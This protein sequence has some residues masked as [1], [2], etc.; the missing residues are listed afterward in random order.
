MKESKLM[1]K[2]AFQNI[3][4]NKSVYLPYIIASIFVL[5]TYF[6]F[7]LVLKSG[8]ME[9]VPR[10]SYAM[11]LVWIGFHLL[12]MILIPFLYYINSF[13]IKRR[14]SELGLYS[15]LGLEKK[16]IGMMM[17][18]ESLYI[19][20]VVYVIAVIIGLLFSKLVF[21]LLS[22][23]ADLEIGTSLYINPAIFKDV[24]LFYG[25]VMLLNLFV[26]LVQ[27]GK[28]KPVDLMSGSKKGEKE[29]KH[30]LP[31][32]LI[33]LL[34]TGYGYYM[35][36]TSGVDS[37]VFMS[38]FLAVALVSGGTHFL[39]TSGSIALL[40]AL[41]KKK[42][43]YYSSK[44]FIMISGMLYRMKKNAASLANICIFSTM[45]TIALTCTIVVMTG[46]DGVVKFM[47]PNDVE[48]TFLN[49]SAE[50][51]EVIREKVNEI[52]ASENTTLT[53]YMDV[54]VY[55]VS[56][57]KVE[58]QFLVRDWERPIGIEDRYTVL[59]MELNEYNRLQ[60]TAETLE[61]DEVL[62]FTT[63][64]DY[65]YDKIILTDG[66]Y[67]AKELKKCFIDNKA[68]L[69]TF[70]AYYVIV[71]PGKDKMDQLAASY[72]ADLSVGPETIHKFKVD[73]QDTEYA[74]FYEKVN[75]D[76]AAREGFADI[77]DT[78]EMGIYWGGLFGGLIFIGIF[79]S[80]IFIICLLVI[81]YYKQIAEGYEDQK[82]FDTMQKE[83]SN[84]R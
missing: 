39:F 60:E 17:F 51:K 42:G 6:S 36:L 73:A 77:E 28:A 50:Q 75:N 61:D 70:E 58:D 7:D 72:G 64:K 68:Q 57:D 13:L 9:S 82:N 63:G 24:A 45:A 71:V 84:D 81:M 31:M 8:V 80:V 76:M 32:A 44:N 41:K 14:K 37:M 35:A 53:S 62:L 21:A 55:N 78:R 67:S 10:A 18:W 15:I 26:N 46:L 27:V 12:G 11:M 66:T 74:K 19:Y 33:G 16:H 38:F 3:R 59:F 47:Y 69:N 83:Q 49:E 43:T 30:I 1:P 2:L 65:G 25:V 52:A 29:T 23:V 34:M 20:A 79:Y 54:T 22:V 56:I 4:N 40:N 5:F 48:M